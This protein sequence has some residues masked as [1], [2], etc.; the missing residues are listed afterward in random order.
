MHESIV[1]SLKGIDE[2]AK[3]MLAVTDQQPA[4]GAVAEWASLLKISARNLREALGVAGSH[5]QEH[6]D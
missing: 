3:R 1:R 5:R 2:V 6:Q 4:P